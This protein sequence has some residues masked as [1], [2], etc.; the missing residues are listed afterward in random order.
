MR[1]GVEVLLVRLLEREKREGKGERRRGEEGE[2]G[3][4]KDWREREEKERGLDHMTITYKHQTTHHQL[5]SKRNYHTHACFFS[6]SPPLS[7]ILS[8]PLSLCL[9][10]FG[11]W[12]IPFIWP[13]N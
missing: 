7:L 2:R 4:Q 3:N 6:L 5:H 8:L 11:F 10:R 1:E 12:V 13:I 9:V